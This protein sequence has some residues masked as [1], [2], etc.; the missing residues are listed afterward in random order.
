MQRL[1][2]KIQELQDEI[3]R[4]AGQKETLW[5]VTLILSGSPNA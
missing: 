5:E 3:N 4:I 2:K 1:D